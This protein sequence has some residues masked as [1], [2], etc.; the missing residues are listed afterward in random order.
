MKKQELIKAINSG[1]LIYTTA[2][3]FLKSTI[4]WFEDNI[5]P[6]E[7]MVEI[8]R[9]NHIDILVTFVKKTEFESRCYNTDFSE[10][11]KSEDNDTFLKELC[12]NSEIFIKRN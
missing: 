5:E 12:E 7:Y 10:V 8:C 6:S 11:I 4:T 9:P 3:E 2:N 1:D